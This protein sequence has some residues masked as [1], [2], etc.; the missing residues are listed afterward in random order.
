MDIVEYDR[1]QLRIQHRP[2]LL[3]V[4]GGILTAL[5]LMVINFEKMSTLTC[6]RAE[7]TSG[8][9]QLVESGLLGSEE[10]EIP[11]NT[12]Q[13]VKVDLRTNHDGND[14]YRVVFLTKRGEFPFTSYY[15]SDTTQQESITSDIKTFIE[16]PNQTSLRIQQDDRLFSYL[17]GSLIIGV[18]I[19]V[20]VNKGK[21]VTCSFDKTNDLM[22]LK[23]RGLLGTKVLELPIHQIAGVTTETVTDAK[24]HIIRRVT[25]ILNS[26]KHFPLT[27]DADPFWDYKKVAYYI[28]AFLKL[29]KSVEKIQ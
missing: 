23:E 10:T 28:R 4:L 1:T 26:G 13:N 22:S 2:V 27:S 18:G 15:S 12:L 25:L 8:S 11:L 29:N 6:Q 21:V 3:W 24:E 17:F 5:G 19:F 14:T 7:S 9:C 20:I 16:N